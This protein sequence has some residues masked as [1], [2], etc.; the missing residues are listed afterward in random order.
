MLEFMPALEHLDISNNK[1]ESHLIEE[2]FSKLLKLQTLNLRGNYLTAFPK[3]LDC[4][5]LFK[6]DFSYNCISL[7]RE[8]D[9]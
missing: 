2:A 8:E 9:I 1:L 4:E 3:L 6:T 7:L 5:K